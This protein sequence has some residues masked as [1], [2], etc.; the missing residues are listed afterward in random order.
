MAKTS[1]YAAGASSTI[2]RVATFIFLRW[3][4]GHHLPPVIFTA[5]IVY[6]GSFLQSFFTTSAYEVI[7]D[8]I[9]IISKEIVD[10]GSDTE[11]EIE[12]A[13][14]EEVKDEPVKEIDVQETIVVE[15]KDPSY[16]KSLLLGLPSPTSLLCS[17]TTAAINLALVYMVVDM[18]YSGPLL[19]QSH[20]LSFARVGYVSPTT[21]SILI[22]EPHAK[23]LPLYVSYRYADAPLAT[24]FGY[25]PPDTAWK[26]ATSIGHAELEETTDY[27]TAITLSHLR[28]DTRYQYA[29]SNNKTGHF[30]TAPRIGHVSKRNGGKF[31][32][33]TTSCIKPRFPYNPFS[34]TLTIPGFKH[35][36]DLIPELK[37]HFMLFLGDFIYIDVPRRLGT[38][39][40]T[41]RSEYRR[42]YASPDWPSVSKDLPWIH[43]LDD[44]EIANDWDKNTTGLWSAAVDPF[45]HYQVAANPPAGKHGETYFTFTQGPASFFMMDTRRY[46]SPETKNASDESKS[47]LGS[48]QL[49][50]LLAF[51]HAPLPPGVKWKIVASSIPFTKNWRF[52]GEDTWGGYLHERK[53]I[54]EAMWAA[55]SKGQGVVVLSG[56]RHEFAATAFPPPKTSNY[57]ASATVYEFSVSPLSMFYLP[58]R[59]YKQTD[60]EDV[61]IQYLP[62]GNSKFGAV[63]ITPSEDGSSSLLHYRLFIDGKEAWAHTIPSPPAAYGGFFNPA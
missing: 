5:A 17:L 29:L 12:R 52:G 13:D 30:I 26:H 28:P 38:D 59:T 56:D 32:F 60:D 31:T 35:L 11:D 22:R 27:T 61:M 51:L 41:Y 53:I 1:D 62:D 58:I 2:L 48:A 47:M 16:L 7:S 19:H 46:R 24:E 39:A 44:H 10:P 43:V 9:D 37:A 33:L 40:E 55:G 45:E 25:G 4:P 18:V 49:S 14:A 50:D 54:L 23:E 21:A 63:E 8:E 15:E 36:A 3:I 6:L 57:P 42:V 20:D 34:H